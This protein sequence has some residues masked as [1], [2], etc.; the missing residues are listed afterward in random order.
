MPSNTLAHMD[1]YLYTQPTPSSRRR[2]PSHHQHAAAHPPLRPPIPPFSL[3][4]DG[5]GYVDGNVYTVEH[6]HTISPKSDIYDTFTPSDTLTPSL[7]HLPDYH[8]WRKPTTATRLVFASPGTRLRSFAS[9][10]AQNGAI[11]QTFRRSRDSTLA[12]IVLAI[13]DA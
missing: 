5:D 2:S 11:T 6:L 9:A 1:L 8:F 10:V 12:V 4:T 13:W 7:H 3:Y